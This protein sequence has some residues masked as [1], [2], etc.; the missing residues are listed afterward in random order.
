MIERLLDRWIDFVRDHIY[1][2]TI[3]ISVSL[4]GLLF[5]QYNLIKL[6][7]DIQK[8]KLDD[9]IED[10]L[11]DMEHRIEDDEEISNNLKVHPRFHRLTFLSGCQF[12]GCTF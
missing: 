7:I 3:L 1:M 6:E 5:V 8:E 12:R 9:E 10:V 11:S 4:I 2:I